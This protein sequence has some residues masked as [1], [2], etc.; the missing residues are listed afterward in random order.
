MEQGG[1][2]KKSFEVRNHIA[3]KNDQFVFRMGAIG[4]VYD[5]LRSKDKEF[6]MN[7]TGKNKYF[8]KGFSKSSH[9][10]DL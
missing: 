2:L 6:V 9:K 5:K 10:K 8:S 4:G 1:N 3:I 7:C